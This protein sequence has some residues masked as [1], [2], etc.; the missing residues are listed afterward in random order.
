MKIAVVMILMTVLMSSTCNKNPFAENVVSFWV[1]NKSGKGIAFLVS[2]QYPDTSIPDNYNGINGVQINGKTPYDFHEK[3]FSKVFESLPAD[4][5]TVFIF[6]GDTLAAYSWQQIR[7]GYKIAKRYD[8]SH[9]DL[10]NM[11]Y[12]IT[13]P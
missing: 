7:S 4:T 11:N 13:Y 6:A 10:E 8:L 2:K 5:L 9:Q 3:N 12:I 1:E